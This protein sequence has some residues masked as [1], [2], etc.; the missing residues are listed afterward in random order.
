MC[1]T[2]KCSGW[3]SKP[4]S[5]KKQYVL[6]LGTTSER[7]V[8]SKGRSKAS[9]R[10]AKSATLIN[11]YSHSM[12]LFA[13]IE[14]RLVV[15]KSVHRLIARVEPSCLIVWNYEVCG[16]KLSTDYKPVFF[17]LVHKCCQNG[18]RSFLSTISYSSVIESGLQKFK[19]Q[20]MVLKQTRTVQKT[21]V[22]YA[23]T[24]NSFILA[25]CDLEPSR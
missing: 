22:I 6:T 14:E 1:G 21:Q 19:F 15:W 10:L 24:S 13:T 23:L 5:Q 11:R 12:P 7:T 9:W 3:W 2:W 18:C 8:F 4:T 25:N 20:F 17:V 16:V